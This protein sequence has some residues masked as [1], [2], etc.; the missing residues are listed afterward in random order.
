MKFIQTLALLILLKITTV[1]SKPIEIDYITAIVNNDIILNSDIL[2][3]M[4]ILQYNSNNCFSSKIDEIQLYD[5]VLNQLITDHLFIQL[6]TK[7]NIEINLKTIDQEISTIASFRNMTLTQYRTYLNSIGIDY[8]QY[9]SE[10][11]KNMIKKSICNYTIYSQFNHYITSNEIENV[12]QTLNF[13]NFNKQFKLVH[14]IIDTPIQASILEINNSINLAKLIIQ[15]RKLKKDFNLIIKKYYEK[16]ILP[17]IIIKKIEQVSWKNIPVIFDQYLET[18]KKGDIIGPIQSYNGI[19]IL[20]IQDICIKECIFPVIKVKINNIVSK[21]HSKDTNIKQNLL[22]IKNDIEQ[23][24]TTFT[25]SAKENNQYFYS[26][27]Y[28]DNVEWIDLD[29]CESSIQE[30][31]LSLKNNQISMPIYTSEGW[32]LV[33]LIKMNKLNYSEIIYERSYYHILHKK[34]N[35]ILTQWIQQLKSQSYIK[36]IN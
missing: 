7:N 28:G 11:Y 17:S 30:S 13:I 12:S 8:H 26:N 2:N 31:L 21:N 35:T 23:N 5:T 34:F 25:I 20:E 14:I 1:L 6:A 3:K 4:K 27:H 24:N 16:N 36:I 33:K 9:F 19:H 22:K 32:C 15:Q 10:I 29:D 18:A